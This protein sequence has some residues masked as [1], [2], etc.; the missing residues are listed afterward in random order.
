MQTPGV[1][2]AGG[3]RRRVR[4]RMRRRWEKLFFLLVLGFE[5]FFSFVR[6]SERKVKRWIFIFT[7][8][9]AL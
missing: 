6:F 3:E 1:L 8:W 7:T 9:S 2:L 5:L 4:E